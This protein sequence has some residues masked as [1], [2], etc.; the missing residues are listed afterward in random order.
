MRTNYILKRIFSAITL[1][2]ISL[3]GFGQASEKAEIV[4]VSDTLRI[5]T[6]NIRI[7]T[8]ADSGVCDWNNRKM[9]VAKL[10]YRHQPDI[11]GVQEIVNYTQEEDLVKLL[12]A[13]NSVT[14]GRGNVEG[15]KGERLGIFYN[16]TR[17]KAIDNGFF[18]LSETPELASKGWDA[19][20][21]RICLWIKLY[22]KVTK[23]SIVYFD[24]HF[25]HK[26]TLARIESAKLITRK[27]KEIAGKDEAFCG[28]DLNASLDE[29]KVFEAL[30]SYLKDTK[31]LSETAPT[32]SLGTF[33]GWDFTTSTF[34]AKEQLDYIFGKNI[35]V[36]N[37]DV[38]NERTSNGTYPSD[39]FPVMIKVLFEK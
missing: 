36:L 33:N 5:M 8:K 13:Y 14:K 29:T 37:Y 11:L 20:L 1:I 4:S 26:G 3:P 28:G 16:K 38:L 31:Q 34:P 6:Y 17:F 9:E 39:H 25:D 35:R 12:P 10:I 7:I 18:F 15:T 30:N 23:R 32:G 19:A 27:I 24:V 2:I 21:N 22:D